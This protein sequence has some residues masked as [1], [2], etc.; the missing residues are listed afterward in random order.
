MA[1]RSRGATRPG[2]ARPTRRPNQRPAGRSGPATAADTV[3][4][5]GA[6]A[7]IDDDSAV[8]FG[9]DLPSVERADARGR[10]DRAKVEP[11]PSTRVRAGQTSNLLA[12]RAAEEYAYVA[13]DVRHIGIVGGGLLAV[14][15][16]LYVLIEV[17]NVLPFLK[18]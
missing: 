6:R 15:L 7:A 2:Q 3:R 17:L 16:V 10:R 18:P 12:A 11:A 4:P 1:K 13:R 9:Q 8:D 5:T 14:L